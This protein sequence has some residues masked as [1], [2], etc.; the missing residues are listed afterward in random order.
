[1]LII[2]FPI[3]IY[4]FISYIII[5]GRP[6]IFKQ[7]RVGYKGKKFKFLNLEQ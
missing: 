2:F 6:I 1:M 4:N 7:L 3:I 5:D